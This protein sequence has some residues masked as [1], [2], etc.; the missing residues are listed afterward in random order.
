MRPVAVRHAG[1]TAAHLK[2]YRDEQGNPEII[3]ANREMP[4]KYLK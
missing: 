2:S 3:G 1:Y 4:V